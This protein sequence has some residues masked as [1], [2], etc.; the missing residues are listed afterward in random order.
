MTRKTVET[1][2][3]HVYRK[4]DISGR[5]EL[6]VLWLADPPAAVGGA[7]EAPPPAEVQG[8]TQGAPRGGGGDVRTVDAMESMNRERQAARRIA[9]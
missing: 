9:R 6:A 3:G 2:L 7:P 1:H 8:A 5:G 4:L